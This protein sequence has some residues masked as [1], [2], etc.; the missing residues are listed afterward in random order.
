MKILSA[1]A[2]DTGNIRTNNEDAYL[3]QDEAGLYAVADGVGGYEGGEVASRI[4]VD[5]LAV[6]LPDLLGDKD[7]TPPQGLTAAAEREVAALRSAFTLANR[8]IRL[9]REQKPKLSGMG[10]T[11]TALLVRNG[12]AFIVHIGDSRAYCFR[13]GELRQLT[14]DHSYVAEQVRAGA[15]TP[16]QARISQYRHVIT[17]ALGIDEE[18]LPDDAVRSIRQGDTFLL[19]TDGLTEMVDDRVIGNILAN[20]SPGDAVKRL[21]DEAKKNGGVDNIT[22]VVV[23]VGAL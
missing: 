10:T 3:V 5:T 21:V 9:D 18:I 23:Q 22:A 17:R 13:S 4:A 19:C 7:R 1:A 20:A 15:L 2:T 6:S 14:N 11:L 12:S 8:K 16:L